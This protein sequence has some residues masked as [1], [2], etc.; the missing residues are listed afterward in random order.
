MLD[1]LEDFVIDQG[2]SYMKLDGTTTIASRQPLIDKF[3]ADKSI[4]V[5]ILTTKVGGL[6]VNRNPRIAMIA[7]HLVFRGRN[8]DGIKQ[9]FAAHLVHRDCGRHHTTAGV[10]GIQPLQCTL[11]CTVLTT[12]TV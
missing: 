9:V 12:R 7:N 11:Q 4:F 10:W 3:N 1:I 8:A 6:G 2:Y 5:F